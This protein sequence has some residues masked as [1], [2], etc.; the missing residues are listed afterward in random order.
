MWALYN[1]NSAILGSYYDVN[2]PLNKAIFHTREAWKAERRR[3]L[4]KERREAFKA[5]APEVQ[6][7]VRQE[8][9]AAWEKRKEQ[10]GRAHV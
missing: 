3:K 1:H 9:T 4:D 6:Q 2:G 8:R 5:L 7:K 10:I